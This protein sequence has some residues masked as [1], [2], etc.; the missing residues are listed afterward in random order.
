MRDTEL[1][2]QIL[3]INTP[4]KVERVELVIADKRVDIHLTHKSEAKW[5]CP[6]CGKTMPLYDHS[7]ERS[8]RHLDTCQLQTLLHARVPRVECDEHGVGQ[9]SVPWALPHGR[10]TAMFE[11]LIIDV[12][13]ETGTVTGAVNLLGI[14][15]DEGW[16][17]MDRAVKRGQK[18]KEATVIEH[19]GVDEKAFRKGHSYV[20][21]V[22]DIDKSTVEHVADDRK[23]ESLGAYL[24]GLS[25]E[26]LWGIKAI[27]MDMWDPYFKAACEHIPLAEFRVVFDRFHIMK[28]MGEAVDKVRRQEHREFKAAGGA[29]ADKLTGAKHLFLYAKENVPAEK[30][31]KLRELLRD[32][33]RVGRAWAWK[34][35]LRELWSY[36][37]IGRAHV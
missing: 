9:V 16:G 13:H 25:H 29:D 35:S 21:V 19:M 36:T 5:E 31:S 12:L 2:Q 22:C 10:F 15:W 11:A 30:R 37:K 28:H 20:T 17:V 18:R 1:Y 7:A 6:T 33:L 4:W 14:T 24:G 32:N 34:E 26:Q 23:A 3:G 27:A 8:W